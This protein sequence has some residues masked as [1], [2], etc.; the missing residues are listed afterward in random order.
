M[1]LVERGI[2]DRALLNIVINSTVLAHE[3]IESVSNRL[4]VIRRRMSDLPAK[5]KP[6][7]VVEDYLKGKK[8]PRIDVAPPPPRP[9]LYIDRIAVGVEHGLDKLGDVVIFPIDKIARYARRLQNK[10]NIKKQRAK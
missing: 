7:L 3:Y 6:D 1:E 8:T 2:K 9:Q 4:E 10:S 5:R